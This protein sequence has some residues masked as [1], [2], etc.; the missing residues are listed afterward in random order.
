MLGRDRAS[1][2]QS[3]PT[4]RPRFD[5][6]ALY[7][8]RA[9]FPDEILA[10]NTQVFLGP[11]FG[12]PFGHWTPA[13]R[14]VGGGLRFGRASGPHS[15]RRCTR[16][17]T[18]MAPMRRVL[19]LVAAFATAC[20]GADAP[21]PAPSPPADRSPCA[22]LCERIA[23]CGAP[24]SFVGVAACTKACEEDDRARPQACLRPR[25]AYAQCVVA[26]PCEAV[27][28]TQ[29]IAVAKHGPCGKEIAAVLACDPIAPLPT[30]D[31]QF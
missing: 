5:G 20:N 28:A 8:S 6:V 4:P 31:F 25:H 13:R 7:P 14:V 16:N 18:S 11:V 9:L 23:S 21:K 30:I 15:A 26:V 24:P 29:D 19:G 27:R 12:A 17:V 3:R 2:R 1:A 22:A 10:R